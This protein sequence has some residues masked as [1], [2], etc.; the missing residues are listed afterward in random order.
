LKE[1]LL[2]TL[3]GIL[4]IF[5]VAGAILLGSIPFLGVILLVYILGMRELY[6]LFPEGNSTQRWISALPG[7]VM[8]LMAYAVLTYQWNYLL[9]GLPIAIWLIYSLIIGFESTSVLSLFWLAIPLA[10]Y[11]SVGWIE[12]NGL[13]HARVPLAMISLIWINDTFAYVTGSL[14]GKHKLAPRL[15]PGKSWEGLLGGFLFSLLGGWTIFYVT[16]AYNLGVW[17]LLS[18]LI[19]GLSLCGDLFESGL[20][21]KRSVKNSGEIL[22][23]HG[24]ILDRFDS[25]FFVAPGA[26]ILFILLNLLS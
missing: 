21:R 1:L 26:F 16:G 18:T 12:E 25:L 3:T 9:L 22:P 23:G 6:A 24:G 7:I 19:S 13:Y 17:L 5:L 10:S 14:I 8:L 11:Y 2:R 15:S 4:L 20:K